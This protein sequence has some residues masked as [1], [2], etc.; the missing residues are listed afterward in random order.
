MDLVFVEVSRGKRG[1]LLSFTCY[2]IFRFRPRFSSRNFH[3]CSFLLIIESVDDV[4]VEVKPDERSFTAV[5][6]HLQLS[7]RASSPAADTRCSTP[8]LSL[9]VGP[10]AVNPAVKELARELLKVRGIL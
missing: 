1:S 10:V 7:S 6:F 2:R 3:D 5:P 8:T 4:K 9:V